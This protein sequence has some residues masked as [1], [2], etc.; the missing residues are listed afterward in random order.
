MASRGKTP[1][2]PAHPPIV[3]VLNAFRSRKIEE[4]I[5]RVTTMP[6][7]SPPAPKQMTSDLARDVISRVEKDASPEPTHAFQNVHASTFAE[8]RSR[9]AELVCANLE[10]SKRQQPLKSPSFERQLVTVV[11]PRRSH[12]PP[13][14]RRPVFTFFQEDVP[15]GR[16]NARRHTSLSR[17]RPMLQLPEEVEP[18]PEAQ[19]IG[20]RRVVSRS[21]IVLFV[22]CYSL[23]H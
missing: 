19:T 15:I 18:L 22:N 8:H 10:Q 2:M 16:S 12:E 6:Q 11:H 1:P 7:S 23:Q 17:V 4:I 20:P 21:S 14:V 13:V 3:P 5:Q 9:Q